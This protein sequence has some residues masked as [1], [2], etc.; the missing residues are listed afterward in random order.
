[1]TLY[2]SVVFEEIPGPVGVNASPMFEVTFEM[3]ADKFLHYR[4]DTVLGF[5][6]LFDVLRF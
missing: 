5:N 2:I 6:F 4:I 3:V 1:M